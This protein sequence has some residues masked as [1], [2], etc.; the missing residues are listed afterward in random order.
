MQISS[1]VTQDQNNF[2]PC[3][4][5][6]KGKDLCNDID[7]LKINDLT[8]TENCESQ[9]YP[10]ISDHTNSEKLTNDTVLSSIV[11]DSFSGHEAAGCSYKDVNSNFRMYKNVTR[12]DKVEFLE[13]REY[14]LEALKK[15]AVP[16]ISEAKGYIFEDPVIAEAYLDRL[17]FLIDSF[18]T[19][20]LKFNDKLD[21]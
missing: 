15:S 11:A 14:V 6:S 3:V 8:L 9:D 10:D 16:D 19:S 2:Q 7:K 1:N 20:F 12:E 21:I 13:R 17:N 18:H 5:T 4:L